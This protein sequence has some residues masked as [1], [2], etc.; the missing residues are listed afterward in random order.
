MTS[1]KLVVTRRQ[2]RFRVP[3]G[4]LPSSTLR[5]PSSPFLPFL[6][7]SSPDS[8]IE[9]SVGELLLVERK[10][11]KERKN[12]GKIVAK[13]GKIEA[14]KRRLFYTPFRAPRHRGC[15]RLS[16]RPWSLALESAR[17][18]CYSLLLSLSTLSCLV[19]SCP[20]PTKYRT[21]LVHYARL[22]RAELGTG[23]STGSLLFFSLSLPLS[24]PPSLPPPS[25]DEESPL[26]P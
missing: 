19:L 23:F 24:F 3:N 10:K 12:R 21:Y 1:N 6:S 9:K 16:G 7:L 8:W 4:F 5:T 17:A 13:L 25:F 22:A 26:S 2:L 11:K 18:R 14:R 20:I 15:R